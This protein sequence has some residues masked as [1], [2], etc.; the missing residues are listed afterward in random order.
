MW[1][2]HGDPFDDRQIGRF[3]LTIQPYFQITWV[4]W[5]GPA[6]YR[7]TSIEAAF[8][9][10]VLYSIQYTVCSTSARIQK[11]V[12]IPATWVQS[13]H[14]GFNP[15]ILWAQSQH[16]WVQFQHSLGSIPP[17]LGSIPAFFGLNRSI[18]GSIQNSFGLIPEFLGSIPALFG[19]NPN[20]LGFNSS[21]LWA[22]TQHSWFNPSILW[23]QSHHPWVQSQHSLC[24]IPASLDSVPAS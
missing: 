19:L 8:V 2:V 16:P 13:Q 9:Q 1:T 6:K 3:A 14:P 11:K 24:S 4:T 17:S 15:S 18:L 23:A 21:I 22:Q 10:V 12:S 7:Y 20:I 5:P